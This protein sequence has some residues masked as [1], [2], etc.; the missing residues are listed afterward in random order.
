MK[1]NVMKLLLLGLMIQF[2]FAASAQ[3]SGTERLS[4]VATHPILADVV[5]Q[6]T[7]DAAD[8]TSLMAAGV[9][10]HS[11]QPVPSDLVRVADADVVFINGAFFEEGLLEAIE[12]AG[13]DINIQVVSNCIDILPFGEHEHEEGE[14]E[15]AEDEDMM[16]PSADID[17]A[18]AARCAEHE[19]EMQAIHDN[20]GDATDMADNSD[21]D[22]NSD[23]VDDSDHEDEDHDHHAGETLGKLYTLNCEAGHHEEEGEGEEEHEHG[24]C[25]PHVWTEPHNVMLWTMMIRDVLSEADPA[26]AATYEANAAVYLETLDSLAHDFI[27][28]SVDTIPEANR[29]LVTNHE[30]LGYFSA[31]YGFEIIDTVLPGGS[32]LADASAGDIATVIDNIREQGVIA[33][34]AENTLNDNVARQISDEA[35]V[36]IAT[37]YSDSLSASGGPASTYLD[38]MRYNVTTIVEALGGTIVDTGS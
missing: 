23:M 38:Y 9:D 1:K 22:D 30:T 26:N 14:E 10:P 32:A 13:S 24:G 11:F 8:V 15:D 18:V 34:F 27:A 29:L 25:D 35:D 3:D 37:L 28:P 4:I 16:M 21:M 17:D 31:R 33:I 5:A 6:V 2:A 12:N 7:G 19:S 20:D 36:Q